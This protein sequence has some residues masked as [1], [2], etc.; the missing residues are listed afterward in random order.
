MRKLRGVQLHEFEFAG[1][2]HHVQ[3]RGAQARAGLELDQAL[4]L[5]QQ[6][7]AAAVGRVIGN[8]DARAFGQVF[9]AGVLFGINAHRKGHRPGHAHELVAPVGHL[10]VQIGLVLVAVG[11]QVARGQ[12]GI[13]LHVVAEFHHFNGQP[14]RGGV[15]FHLFHDFG[16]RAGGGAHLE[17][18]WVIGQRQRRV[19]QQHSG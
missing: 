4:P 1:V 7:R 9:Q 8:A 14:L 19:R 15:L 17:H 5:Q 3:R 2:F 12:R 10:L 6:Q 16:V 11:L 13:G 18:G